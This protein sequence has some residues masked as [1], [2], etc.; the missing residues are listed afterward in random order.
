M[1][2]GLKKIWLL[3]MACLWMYTSA[4]QDVQHTQQY[5]NRLFLNPAF[6]GLDHSW[7]VGVSHRKQWPTLNG[8][9]VTNSLAAAFRIPD[10]K[11]AISLTLQQDRAGVGGLKKLQAGLGYAYH[12]NLSDSWAMSAGLQASINRLN[13]DYDNLVFGDQL[14]DNGM[15]A[16][17][18]AEVLE[19]NPNTYTDFTV[20]GL[21]YSGQAWVGLTAAH[22]N[23]PTYDLSQ[24]TKLPLRFTAVAGYKFYARSYEERGQLFELSF[25]PAATF[26][27]QQ[28]S[29]RLD[30]G[31]YTKYTPLTLGIIY[32]G[33]PAVGGTN[34]DQSLSL[35]AGLQLEQL[36][37]GFSHD[38]GLKG[39]SREMGGT[40]EVSLVFEGADFNNLFRSRLNRKINRGIVCPAF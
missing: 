24:T 27:H 11:S 38:V 18:S 28:S 14:S 6:A 7:S 15:V 17:R 32:K 25:T 12:T 21:L 20:G 2:A 37:A 22:L 35:M 30:L 4:A 10:S 29:K 3:G 5:A 13:L 9:F 16:V 26:I 39:I 8:S 34:Q 31:L 23:Q 19:F 33:V 36:R 40:N 1:G